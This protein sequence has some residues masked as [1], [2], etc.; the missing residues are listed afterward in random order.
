MPVI[1][2]SLTRSAILIA[3]L[4][5]FTWYGSSVIDQAGAALELFDVDD[6]AHRDRA[7]AGAVGVLDALD[8]QDLRAGGE[9]GALDALDQRFEQLF[10]GG[11]GVLQVPEGAGGH[12]AQVVRR[13]VGG[14]TDGDADRAVDQQVREAGRAAR[15]ARGCGRRSCPGSRRCLRRCRAPS[16][17]RA[18]PSWSRCIAGRRR[19]RC[20]GSR[21]CPGRAPA[22][23][24]GSTA[25]RGARGRRRSRSHRAG[26]TGPSRRRRRGRTWRTPCR[27]GSRRRTWRR[28]RGGARASCRRARRAARGPTMTLI[29]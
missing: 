21:S 3:R 8:A 7:A 29:A 11:V 26:G 17:G 20:R 27:G 22:G 10:A 23:S 16:R 19:R 13:D 4:S 1:L 5:G 18:G 28:S 25:A 9:V 24:A 15:W 2:P 6:G 14:H 12:L